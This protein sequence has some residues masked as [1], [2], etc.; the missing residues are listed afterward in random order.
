MEEYEIDVMPI[1]EWVKA[2][3]DRICKAS[4]EEN[5]E[6]GCLPLTTITIQVNGIYQMTQTI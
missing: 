2:N 4:V 1:L 5:I 3:A 6:W